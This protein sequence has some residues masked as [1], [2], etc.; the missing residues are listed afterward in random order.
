[1]VRT[2]LCLLLAAGTLLADERLDD[3]IRSLVGDAAYAENKAF[4][5][6]VFTPDTAFMENDRLDVVKIVGTLK[7]NGL[8]NLFFDEPKQLELTFSTN[9][10]P[11]FFVKLMGET[12]RSMG[13]YRY[14]TDESRLD[15]SSFFWKIRLATEYATDPVILREELRKRHC[16]VIDIERE[17]PT[18]WTYHIDMS[19]AHLA[20]E[21]L[22]NG[23]EVSFN[24]SLEA[25][26][27]DVSQ[28][29]SLTIYSL[30]GN[31]WYPYVVFYDSSMRLLK[32]Y[33]RDRKTWEVTLRPP[34]DA[35]YV[36]LTDLYTLKNIK[37]GFK[38]VSKGVK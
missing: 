9:G 11:L 13:Y 6:I 23:K 35:A 25:H 24:R 30:R 36:K 2:L 28:V 4:I 10:S 33:K 7:E 18:Q 22:Q 15:N 12:L 31:N 14:I 34:R 8:M 26:W 37:D 16:D 3:K 1:L 21:P 29:A 27:L 19:Q 17:S 5:D 20:L 32:V 38:I